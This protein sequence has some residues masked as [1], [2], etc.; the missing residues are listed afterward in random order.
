MSSAH[1]S[2][3]AAVHTA[4]LAVAERNARRLADRLADEAALATAVVAAVEEPPGT[5]RVCVTFA[6]RPEAPERAALTHAAVAVLGEHAPEFE[7]SALPATDWVAK[8]LEGLA[9]VAAGRFLVHGSH[10]RR[11]LPGG[12]V[13][14]EIDA[15][16][17][18]GTGH[19]ATT[20]GCLLAIDHLVATRRFRCPLD[21][22]TGSGVLAIAIA[23]TLRVPVLAVDIDPVAVA[24]AHANAAL[25]DVAA[26]VRTVAAA[27]VSHAVLRAAAPFDLVVANIL[28]EPLMRL[29]PHVTRLLAP[30]GVLVLSGLLP[31]Q[32]ARV[33]AAY[34]VE[35][36]PL[37][38]AR[39]VDGWSVLVL[40]R[41]AAKRSPSDSRL[42]RRVL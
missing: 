23:K 30:G 31:H 18:F 16:L 26:R 8:S 11:R 24:V 28:A 20:R 37:V 1:A 4:T 6:D 41:P 35:G 10:D 38:D 21:L 3:G 33:A 34:A 39:T 36:V 14:V 9:P 32:R 27:G 19:H 5:W 15:G 2:G 22:G 7:I 25:N 12:R 42:A 29:A 13:T 17:A 40:R